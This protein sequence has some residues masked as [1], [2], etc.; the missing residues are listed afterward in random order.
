M[1]DNISYDK[2]IPAFHFE[3]SFLEEGMARKDA[4]PVAF[5]EVSGIGI[6]LQTEDIMEGGGNNYVIR[7]PKP[8][9]FRN[10]VLKRALSAT[11]PPDLIPWA[12]NAVEQFIIETRTVIVEVLDYHGTAVKTWNF[13]KA[14]PVKLV[15]TDLNASKNEAIIETIEL[16]YRQFKQM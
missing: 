4:K 16:A 8:P 6:E 12:K 10:L 11:P 15:L 5:S 9:K 2:L 1:A 13:E 3:V 14:Y 7:L